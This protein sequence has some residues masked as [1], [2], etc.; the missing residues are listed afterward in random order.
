M[1]EGVEDYGYLS[2]MAERL[3][4]DAARKAAQST[5][6]ELI[7]IYGDYYFAD[8]KQQSTLAETSRLQI[9]DQLTR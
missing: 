1:R 9:L 3:K 4:N 2:L 7:K 6:A 8:W 5:T